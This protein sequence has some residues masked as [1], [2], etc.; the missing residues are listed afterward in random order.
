[1]KLIRG[2]LMEAGESDH[3]GI[4]YTDTVL[5]SAVDSLVGSWV[6]FGFTDELVGRVDDAW[7]DDDDGA[8]RYEA[9]VESEDLDPTLDYL[10]VAPRVRVHSDDGVAT[11]LEYKSLG[12]VPEA[13]Q[14]V[15]EY[16]VLDDSVL[17][18]SVLDDEVI[19]D[20]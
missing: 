9:V 10:D 17:D 13:G 15:G 18:D 12:L 1:M 11:D 5:A 14:L 20:G 7:Y 4:T 6:T 8:V 19:D 2:Q 3:C 16:T